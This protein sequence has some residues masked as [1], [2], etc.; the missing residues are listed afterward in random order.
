MC[1]L[2]KLYISLLASLKI[3]LYID[4]EIEH[5]FDTSLD[6]KEI[7]PVET[8]YFQDSTILP[9]TSLVNLHGKLCCHISEV[10]VILYYFEISSAQN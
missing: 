1:T 8:N 10:D 3:T 6:Q 9:T 7:Q 5:V 2:K 4:I